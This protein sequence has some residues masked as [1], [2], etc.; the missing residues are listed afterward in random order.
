M[1]KYMAMAMIGLGLIGCGGGDESPSLTG[2]TT[3]TSTTVPAPEYHDD[4][5]W[6]EGERISAPGVCPTEDSCEVMQHGGE[7]TAHP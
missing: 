4:G 6:F 7:W 1:R 2:T 3:S 5:W